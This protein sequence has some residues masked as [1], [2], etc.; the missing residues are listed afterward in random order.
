[1]IF[2]LSRMLVFTT[3]LKWLRHFDLSDQIKVTF[4]TPRFRL[5][6]FSIMV[7]FSNW[8]M[9]KRNKKLVVKC[10]ARSDLDELG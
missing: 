10:Q 2:L 8:I 9:R 7:S 3:Q 6:V 4:F 1:M 5:F